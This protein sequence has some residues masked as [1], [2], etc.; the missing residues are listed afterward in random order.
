MRVNPHLFRH[1]GSLTYLQQHP[2][3]FEVMRRVLGHTST[4]TLTKHYVAFEQ[5]AA[6]RMFDET[7]LDLRGEPRPRTRGFT[8]FTRNQVL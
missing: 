2:G 6:V 4:A 5:A 1:F 3:Q 7:I 8:P